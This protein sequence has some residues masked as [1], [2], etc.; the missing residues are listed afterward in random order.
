[1]KEKTFTGAELEKA[2][3]NDEL[4]KS[5]IELVGM[6][7]SSEKTGYVNF[8]R[9]GCD[10]WV[11]LPTNMIEQA[12]NL[13][14]SGCKDHS[15]PVFKIILK[16]SKNPEAQILS[17]LLAQPMPTPSQTMPLPTQAGQGSSPHDFQ[18][19]RSFG[20]PFYDINP[21]GA[22]SGYIR[23]ISQTSARIGTHG[24]GG[25]QGFKLG[26]WTGSCCCGGYWEAGPLGWYWVCTQYCDCERCIIRF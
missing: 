7:K 2:L 14:Q 4:A 20:N 16:E 1:M 26:C 13:G 22:D 9:S 25:S 19:R 11:D 6:V 8:T 17:A 23:S 24:G 15:H 12:E 21:E 5:G 10:T 18:E 3:I